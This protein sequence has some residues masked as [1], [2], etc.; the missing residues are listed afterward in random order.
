MYVPWSVAVPEAEGVNVTEQLELVELILT[1]LQVMV[2]RLP[3][4]EAFMKPKLPPGP[5]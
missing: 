2:L 4:P 5:L 3:E 1:R